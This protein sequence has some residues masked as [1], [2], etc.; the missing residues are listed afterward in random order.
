MPQ[1]ARNADAPSPGAR[2]AQDTAT[3]EPA[4]A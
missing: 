4:A 2:N 3:A 1:Y